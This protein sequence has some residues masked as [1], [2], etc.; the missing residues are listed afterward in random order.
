[1]TSQARTKLMMWLVLVAVFLL[2]SVSGAALTG[3]IRSRASGERP[4]HERAM[5]ERFDKMRSELNL[6]DQQTTAVR[7][8]LEETRNEYRALKT[9]LRPRFEEPRQK[10]RTRIRALLTPEQQQ[11]FDAM[12]AQHDAQRD[13]E[14]KNRR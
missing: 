14:Q 9:E 4:D 10:A 3:L 13:E 5:K 11:K 12:V 1:M 8:I 2:G 7:A 6:S